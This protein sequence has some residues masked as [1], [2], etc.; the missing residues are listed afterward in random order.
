MRWYSVNTAQYKLISSSQKTYLLNVHRDHIRSIRDGSAQVLSVSYIMY[1]G[2][3]MYGGL[4]ASK[5]KISNYL[6]IITHTQLQ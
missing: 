5:D 2:S 3:E 6:H 1:T 4:L